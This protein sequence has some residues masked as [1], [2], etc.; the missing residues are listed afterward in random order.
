M[1]K[2]APPAQKRQSKVYYTME[3]IDMQA[4]RL[5]KVTI[6]EAGNAT[7]EI[8]H[9]NSPQIVYAKLLILIKNQGFVGDT[10]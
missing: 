8:L 7:E 10:P 9:R 2:K 1:S 6:D 4:Y 5:L 3:K